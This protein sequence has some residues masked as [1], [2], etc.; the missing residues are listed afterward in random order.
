MKYITITAFIA[1]LWLGSNIEYRFITEP[2]AEW[3]HAGL[4]I[5]AGTSFA[6]QMWREKEETRKRE[7]E[8]RR[9]EIRDA[10]EEERRMYLERVKA[11]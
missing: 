8:H 3:L 10:D 11:A 4:V 7:R 9:N 5:L 1:A 2:W 6:W